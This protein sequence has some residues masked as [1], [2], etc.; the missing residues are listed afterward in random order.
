MCRTAEQKRSHSDN[1]VKVSSIRKKIKK[2]QAI[3]AA[4]RNNL[5]AGGCKF[6]QLLLDLPPLSVV[7]DRPKLGAGLVDGLVVGDH[8]PGFVTALACLDL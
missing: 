6:V 2:K 4:E 7:A 5:V 1:G 8:A 3:E